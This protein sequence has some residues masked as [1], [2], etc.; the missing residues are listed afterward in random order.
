M[1]FSAINA[2]GLSAPPYFL[3][4]V[5]SVASTWIADRTRQR[6]L[7]IMVASLIGGVGYTILATVQGTGPRYFAVYLVTAG[8]FPSI[9]N[10]APW[11]LNNQG[12]DTKRGT[13][14]VLLQMLGT[15]G[16]LLGTRLYPAAEGPFYV[17]GMAISAAFMYFAALLAL[18]LRTYLVWEN[19]KTEAREAALIAA[20]EGDEKTRV[21]GL[22]NDGFGFR[23]IL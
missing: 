17:K 14:T 4:F 11:T 2:Q 23:Y 1:G 7:V 19:K 21:V 20:G 8:V 6:G 18:A 15:C 16:P 9:F 3:A 13:G 10:V 12:S 22:E 5:L